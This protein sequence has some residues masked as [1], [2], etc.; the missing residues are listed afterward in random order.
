MLLAVE[1]AQLEGA[2]ASADEAMALIRA[3][4]PLP[5]AVHE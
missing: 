4:F 2:I 1:E 5:E 3:Q